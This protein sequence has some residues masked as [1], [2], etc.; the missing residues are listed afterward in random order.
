VV[1]IGRSE[2]DAI[3]RKVIDLEKGLAQECEETNKS[4]DELAS[5]PSWVAQHF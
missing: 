1:E 5:F 3:H 4:P 2:C